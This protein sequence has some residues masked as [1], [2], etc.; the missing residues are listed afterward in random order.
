MISFVISAGFF[1]ILIFAFLY[2]ICFE[3]TVF[4][5]SSKLKECILGYCIFPFQY[6]LLIDAAVMLEE[7][8]AKPYF[9]RYS[10]TKFNLLFV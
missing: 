10:Y 1:S 4:E 2:L 3:D 9:E 6:K 8:P 5:I 7:S